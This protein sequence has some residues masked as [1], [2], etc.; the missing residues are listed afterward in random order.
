VNEHS[1]TTLP[2]ANIYK[3]HLELG[4]DQMGLIE[5]AQRAAKEAEKQSTKKGNK[6]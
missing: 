2:G 1:V 6:Q 3:P 4:V 5:E